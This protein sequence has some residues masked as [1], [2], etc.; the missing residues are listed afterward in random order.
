MV[1][2][3]GYVL[4]GLFT[5][6]GA[7]IAMWLMER[8]GRKK[9]DSLNEKIGEMKGIVKNIELIESSKKPPLE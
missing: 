5:G 8:H 1:D 6:I 7:G 4:Q 3:L 9:L 2:L